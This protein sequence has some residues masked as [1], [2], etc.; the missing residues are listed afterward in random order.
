MSLRSLLRAASVLALALVACSDPSGPA[1]IVLPE[2]PL[3]VNPVDVTVTTQ[4]ARAGS[5]RVTTAGGVVTATAT[6]GTVYTLAL[7][8]NALLFDTTVTIT[9]ITSVSGLDAASGRFIGVKLEPDGIELYEPATLRMQPP[10]GERVGVMGFMAHDG[11]NVYRAPFSVDPARLELKVFHF[12]T[13]LGRINQGDAGPAPANDPMPDDRAGQLQA[14][15][16][17]LARAER[18]RLRDG[19]GDADKFQEN[20]IKVMRSFWER[21]VLLIITGMQFDCQAYIT[22]QHI[23]TTWTHVA[24]V[25]GVDDVFE[26]EMHQ[27][28]EAII[29]ALKNCWEEVTTPCLEAEKVYMAVSIAKLLARVE[30]FG[31]DVADPALRCGVW[32]GSATASGPTAHGPTESLT[33][34][35]SFEVDSVNSQFDAGLIQWRIHNGSLTWR[36]NP[37]TSNNGCPLSAPDRTFVMQPSDGYMIIQPVGTTTRYVAGGALPVAIVNGTESCAG[38]APR[39]VQ[40]IV[41]M[42]LFTGDFRAMTSATAISGTH[43]FDNRTYQWTFSRVGGA[44]ALR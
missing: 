42:W 16:E 35:V 31:Y 37:G 18:E 24:G 44:A 11:K 29:V 7:P 22:K 8:P 12:S 21:E 10:E 43:A 9:P 32:Q 30:V 34:Q 6:D 28:D 25:F 4:P 5:A 19:E 23:A 26:S 1:E 27:V 15:L 38:Q 40:F 36:L 17:I 20:V 2:F 13:A 14:V 3:P 33:A 41:G 39:T